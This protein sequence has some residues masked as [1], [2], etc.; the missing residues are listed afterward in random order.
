M[1]N[2]KLSLSK[3]EQWVSQNEIDALFPSVRLA[4]KKVYEKSGAGNGFLGW[5]DLPCTISEELLARLETDAAKIIN[6]SD[7][8]VVCGI[9]GSYLGARAVID[10]LS[11]PF[12]ALLDKKTRKAPIVVYAG[13]HLNAEYHA[14]LLQLLDT[15]NYSLIVISKSGTTTEPAVAF[16]LLKKHIEKKYGTTQAAERIYAIT[17]ASKGALKKLAT[18]NGYTTYVIPDDV[19]G[20][21]SVLTPVGL[22]PIAASGLNIRE[23]VAGASRMEEFLKNYENPAENPAAMYAIARNILY[24]KGKTTEILAG[25]NPSISFLIEWWKQ[26][27]GE[28]EGKDQKGIFPAGVNFT[29]DLHSLGQYIQEGLRNIFETVLT[30]ANQDQNLTIPHSKDDLDGLNYIAGQEIASVNQKAKI[31]TMLAHVDGGVPNLEITI[32]ELNEGNLGELIYFFEMGCAL[33]GYL[34]GVNPFDQPGVEAYKVNMFALLQKP[35]FE[36]ETEQILKR[37]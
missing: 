5:V 8:V 26:L 9:G 33:S 20:R 2:L 4:S 32:P 11:N 6:Q 31:G 25:Y 18:A 15:V 36:K 1:I 16:R 22:L 29:T 7:I 10:A 30:T 3:A 12:G 34:L 37:L 13:H 19:G 14:K 28:S 17:D 23:L 21:Y 24:H 35:G 27:Y